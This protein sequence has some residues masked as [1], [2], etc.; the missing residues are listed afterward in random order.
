MAVRETRE[1]HDDSRGRSLSRLR[2]AF[3]GVVLVTRAFVLAPAVAAQ[4][5]S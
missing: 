4:V 3:A 2:S 1:L 5:P